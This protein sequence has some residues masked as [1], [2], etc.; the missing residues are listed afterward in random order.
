M[1]HFSKKINTFQYLINYKLKNI[2]NIFEEIEN[3]YYKDCT[4]KIELSKPIFI[5]G[6]ARSGTTTLLNFINSRS[7][8][9]SLKYKNLPFVQLSF[10]N[11]FSKIY[12]YK[13]KS[14][15][16]VHG[17][18]IKVS[19]DSPDSFDELYW[20]SKLGETINK[21]FIDK[22][23]E[24]NINFI[25]K[26]KN[27][28]KKIIYCS[29]SKD[30]RYIAKNNYIVNRLNYLLEIF[31][32]SKIIIMYRDPLDTAISLSNIHKKIINNK[33]SKQISKVLKYL[34]HYEFGNLRKP[35]IFDSLEIE[36]KIY[37]NWD[38][39]NDLIGYLYC[40]YNTYSYL[41]KN[42]N[43]EKYSRNIMFVCLEDLIK[44]NDE[45][46]NVYKFL[47]LDLCDQ[48]PNNYFKSKKYDKDFKELS[49]GK[50]VKAN[51]DIYN[52]LKNKKY[53]FNN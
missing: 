22:D 38:K 3:F 23:Y 39:N 21:N 26:Y 53:T 27:F 29:G 18:G 51:Y 5:T 46:K 19:L 2:I 33:N 9:V 34:C 44:S 52:E 30:A 14:F 45:I 12:Y 4:E 35:I 16:R 15:K 50:I 6:M 42:F 47:D 40:W 24:N 20:F 49:H 13:S 37:E 8:V 28:I 17:D 1:D 11:E 7:N 36:N 41:F 48:V 31:P 10:W 43:S 25:S 32:D